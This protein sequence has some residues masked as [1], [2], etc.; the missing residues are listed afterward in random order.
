VRFLK[1][2]VERCAPFAVAFF[3]VETSLRLLLS[4][5][6]GA[7]ITI[8]PGEWLRIF[9]L[10]ASFDAVVLGY[11]LLPYALYL[12]LL[13]RRWHRSFVDR[14][15]T[16]AG[17]SIG[18]FVLLYTASAEWIFWDEFGVRM[19]FIAVDY[20]VYTREVLA[21]IWESYPVVMLVSVQIIM[22]VVIAIFARRFLA[23]QTRWPALD[24]R[25]RTA[26]LAVLLL[27]PSVL[28][29]VRD[30]ADADI[31]LDSD[32]NELAKNGIYSFFSAF[33]HNELPYQ[34]FYATAYRDRAPPQI[35]SVLGESEL[36]HRFLHPHSD[37]I[38]RLVPGHGA[39]LK[40]NVVVVVMESMSA[41]FMQRFGWNGPEITP[42]LDRL[43][44]ES[45]FFES[46]YA[47]GTR[48]VRGLEAITLSIPPTSGRSIIKRP[49]NENLASIG[50]VFQDR[51]YDTRFIYGGYGYFDNMNHFF[52]NNGFSIVDRASF[53]ESETTF[54][55][56]WGLC[57]EDLYA[58]SMTEAA[59]S[60]AA[61]RPFM[62]LLMTTSNHRP[63]TFPAGRPGIPVSRGGRQAGVKYADYALGQFLKSAAREPWFADTVFVIIADHTA[64]AAGKRELS[65]S[66]YHIPFLIYAPGF[67]EPSVF[68]QLA[69]QID[70]APIL[71][72]LLDFSYVGRFYGEDLLDDPNEQPHVYVANYEKLGYLTPR[73]LV[74]LRP[75]HTIAQY[76]NGKPRIP[77]TVDEQAV[78]KTI[79]VYAHASQWRRHIGRVP[80]LPGSVS[81][82][83]H[84]RVGLN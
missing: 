34:Q 32:V 38:T 27:I 76:V 46:A 9:A 60:H 25:T 71:F 18:V 48:T 17:F 36:G 56:A 78:L 84:A 30:N 63:Y 47:T 83:R 1:Y 57:D 15:V 80:T 52:S 54:A 39:A 26:S 58:K 61:G 24:L 74:I 8:P 31:S 79:A 64:N 7:T 77:P 20:L 13:P 75:D 22:A 51:G 67:V 73:S 10:G 45:L 66:K 43:A 42:V 50:F 16:L 69:S 81:V 6:V 29:F 41:R 82:D 11:F 55:N 70:V 28:F 12:L 21:D 62:H 33:R 14:G 2:V 44:G 65:P 49:G 4:T 59:R 68:S 23:P 37:D 19:N 53:D 40:K 3:I 5:R 72:G 35:Q